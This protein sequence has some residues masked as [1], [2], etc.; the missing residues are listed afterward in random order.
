MF[1]NGYVKHPAK[2]KTAPGEVSINTYGKWLQILLISANFSL[3]LGKQGI[4]SACRARRKILSC[5]FVVSVFLPENIDKTEVICM[6]YITAQLV[7][8]LLLLYTSGEIKDTQWGAKVIKEICCRTGNSGEA[9]HTQTFLCSS[10][11]GEA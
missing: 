9:S 7:S 11:H 4:D 8:R 2:S 1:L 6:S 3:I 5:T 10:F